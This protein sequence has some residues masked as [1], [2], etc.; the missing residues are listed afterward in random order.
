M[1]LS[2][3]LGSGAREGDVAVFPLHPVVSVWKFPIGPALWSISAARPMI[4]N[5]FEKKAGRPAGTGRLADGA[6]EGSIGLTFPG[7]DYIASRP[8]ARGPQGDSWN[9][10]TQRGLLTS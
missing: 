6:R 1:Q 9:R 10:I 8:P 2:L 5:L 7:C 4:F 3:Q